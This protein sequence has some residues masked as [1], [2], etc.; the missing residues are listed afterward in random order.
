MQAAQFPRSF[1]SYALKNAA[2]IK[3]RVYAKPIE[4]VPYQRMFGVKPDIHHICK[5][6]SLAYVHVPVSPEKQKQDANAFVSFVL[7]YAEETVGCQVYIPSKRTVKFLAKVRVQEDITYGDR[8]EVN[9]AD[10]NI[11]EWLTFETVPAN[12]KN[13][14]NISSIEGPDS[15][16]PESE[17][18]MER[19]A[20]VAN[21]CSEVN[22]SVSYKF[23]ESKMA[24]TPLRL[25][26]D[27][28]DDIGDVNIAEELQELSSQI[29]FSPRSGMESKGKVS[30]IADD[31]FSSKIMATRSR[32]TEDEYESTDSNTKVTNLYQI[33]I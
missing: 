5:F 32:S 23:N 29:S 31:A 16:V 30:V 11:A 13:E 21:D 18:S 25:K 6:G 26:Q 15:I 33:R 28:D 14:A 19:V 27:D 17:C 8:H 12:D 10:I 3:N 22:A 4:G 2:Y 1:W 9:P 24:T 7:G 20:N